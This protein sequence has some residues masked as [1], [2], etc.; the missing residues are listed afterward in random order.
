[1][2]C[3]GDVSGNGSIDALD[4]AFANIVAQG[5]ATGFPA[6]QL[7]DPAIVGVVATDFSVDAG[8]VSDLA[9]YTVRLPVEAPIP[10]IPS[11][12]TITPRGPDHDIKPWR[13]EHRRGR[14]ANPVLQW[15]RVRAGAPRSA[16]PGRC[17]YAM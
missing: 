5:T 9:A 1:M 11:G 13:A 4:V 15:D 3:A 12:L 14:I 6:Y 10:A 17:W 2:P 16:A 7:L 8:D